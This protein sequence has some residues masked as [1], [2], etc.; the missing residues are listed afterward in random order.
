MFKERITK[1]ITGSLINLEEQ[2]DKTCI[3][4]YIVGQNE[5][6]AKK[7]F[8]IKRRMRGETDLVSRP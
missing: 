2:T 3:H 6:G 5:E 4:L 7:V 8:E 1:M